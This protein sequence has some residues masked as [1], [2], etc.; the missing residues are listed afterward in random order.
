MKKKIMTE[1][2][3]EDEIDKLDK[4]KFK[5]RGG[6]VSVTHQDKT[7]YSKKHRKKNKI[8]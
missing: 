4:N 5:S 6:R 8:K 2:Q 3:F 7:K 1:K